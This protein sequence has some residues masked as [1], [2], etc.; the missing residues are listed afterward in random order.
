MGSG[1]LRSTY[2][3]KRRGGAA[4]ARV[5]ETESFGQLPLSRQALARAPRNQS[6]RGHLL[7]PH[8]AQ[9]SRSF[10]RLTILWQAS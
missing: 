8:L 10:L 3:L 4:G 1:D 9:T 5:T 7:L 6:R 2:N